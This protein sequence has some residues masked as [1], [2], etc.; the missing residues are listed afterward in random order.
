[1]TLAKRRKIYFACNTRVEKIL[2]QPIYDI[3]I[4]GSSIL[5]R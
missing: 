2:Y 4:I 5:G 3:V 1:M